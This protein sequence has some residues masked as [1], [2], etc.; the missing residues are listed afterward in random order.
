M[1]A[2]TAAA[3]V[4]IRSI[5][6]RESPTSPKSITS[7]IGK[8]ERLSSDQGSE[9]V[10]YAPDSQ[11]DEDIGPICTRLLT[12]LRAIQLGKVKDE[13]NWCFRVT[14]ED[15]TKVAGEP[16]TANGNGHTIDQLD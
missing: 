5:T 8:H 4:P 7:T 9:K 1:A 14:R 11:D 16:D 15:G 6:R 13:F 3:L 12:Q 10:T 2:G